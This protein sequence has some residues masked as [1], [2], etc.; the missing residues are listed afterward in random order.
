MVVFTRVMYQ[1]P[2]ADPLD[3]N[4]IESW[5]TKEFGDAGVEDGVLEQLIGAGGDID[6]MAVDRMPR[7]DFLGALITCEFC[8][9]A[10][11]QASIVGFG[12]VHCNLL[13]SIQSGETGKW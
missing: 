8:P 4:F 12:C 6:A 11:N 1:D 3:V 9:V 5:K 10:R 13:R 7:A 2:D